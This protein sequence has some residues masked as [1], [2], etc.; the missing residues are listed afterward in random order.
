MRL[1][2]ERIVVETAAPGGGVREPVAFT[3]RR[4]R[5][6]VT[7]VLS[8]WVDTGFGAGEVTRTWYNRCHR[9]HYRL[10]TEDGS[11]CEIYLDRSG[12]RRD[13]FLARVL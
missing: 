6:A 10:E 13:W 5:Y 12:Q 8:S 9:N 7:R 11:V 1:V 3:W 2:H 4:K